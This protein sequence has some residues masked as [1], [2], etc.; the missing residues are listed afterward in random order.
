MSKSAK[1]SVCEINE[2]VA[3]YTTDTHNLYIVFG[4]IQH[5]T[6]RMVY[7][8]STTH[9]YQLSGLELR[10]IKYLSEGRN[11]LLPVIELATSEA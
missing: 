3:E 2:H 5:M 1:Q 4:E 7:N 8:T 10:E 6:R 9:L 11:E